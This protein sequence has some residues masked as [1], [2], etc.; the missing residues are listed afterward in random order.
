MTRFWLTL[1]QGVCFVLK[2]I[3]KMHGGEIFVP[4]I[5][6]MTITDLADAIAPEANKEVVGIRPGE[7]LHEIMITEDEA[8]HT[9][10]FFDY[11][12]IEPEFA[13]W[14]KVNHVDGKSLSEGYRYSSDINDRW[15]TKTELR[16][17]C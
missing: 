3:E 16:K 2:S 8:R 4:K 1:D 17:M 14:D 10:E 7:T 13:F 12:I 5:P 9:K 15:L 11:F 6:S